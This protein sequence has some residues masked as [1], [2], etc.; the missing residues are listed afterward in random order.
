MQHCSKDFEKAFGEKGCERRFVIEDNDV[1][2]I[3]STLIWRE[4]EEFHPDVVFQVS[5]A[6]AS[7]DYFPRELPFVSYIQDKC[8]PILELADLSD[9][10]EEQDLFVCMVKEFKRYLESKQ[11]KSEQT[12]VL[13]IPADE[14][15]FYPTS[16]GE[17]AGE[18]YAVDIGFVNHGNIE[19]EKVFE[20][21]LV[22][23]FGQEQDKKFKDK[24]TGVFTDLYERTCREVD[25]CCFE[26]EMQDMVLGQF[27]GDVSEEGRHYMNKLVTTFYITVYVL[28]CRSSYLEALDE[29]GFDLAL[30][31]EFKEVTERREEIRSVGII[32]S[33]V[34]Y[35]FYLLLS[36][37]MWAIK[38]L[39]NGEI[40]RRTFKDKR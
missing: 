33:L 27:G 15:M 20:Q 1:Q 12:L 35:L 38:T 28:A 31:E 26:S 19:P 8:G 23:Y 13:P 32:T 22:N 3:T 14:S 24:L 6:R 30:F 7:L 25:L 10:V 39:S 16:G 21:F 34:I 2:T 17:A 11:V 36:F 37:I 40:A 5:H 4:L 29:A 9:Y 18:D